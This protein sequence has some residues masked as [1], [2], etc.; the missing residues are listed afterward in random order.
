MSKTAIFDLNGVF[1]ISPYLSTRFVGKYG[2]PREKFLLALSK[3]MAV[4]RQPGL[5]SSYALWAPY[6][7]EWN[8][9]LSEDAFFYFWFS[10][11]KEN[12]EMVAL[13]KELKTHDWNLVLLSN[14][15]K[16]RCVYYRQEFD[17]LTLFD[18]V[19]FS[20]ETGLVKPDIV[21]YERIMRDFGVVADDC[22]Y[23]DDSEKNI[24]VASS[25][26]IHSYLFKDASTTR[27]V[28]LE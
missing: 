20:W 25:L 17:F 27:K 19:Y 1:L 18:R 2:V 8:V 13:A 3:V 10:A 22:Y 11:E 12:T 28:L 9:D 5:N 14:N 21:C 23:F 4:A 24:A 15:F 16:E 6:L 26:G 7:D